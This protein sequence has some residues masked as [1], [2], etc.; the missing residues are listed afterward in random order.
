MLQ[1][2]QSNPD[3]NVHP[4]KR[5][6]R[7]ESRRARNSKELRDWEFRIINPFNDIGQE[8]ALP[9]HIKNQIQKL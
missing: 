7:R 6:S 1:L 8:N 4:S 3:L 2:P 9:T 5:K